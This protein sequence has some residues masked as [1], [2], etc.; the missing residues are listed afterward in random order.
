M[1]L[2]PSKI[3]TSRYFY[4]YAVESEHKEKIS[5]RGHRVTVWMSQRK[6]ADV[7]ALSTTRV[8]YQ[9]DPYL[10]H[11]RYHVLASAS[12]FLT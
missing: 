7:R 10:T 3:S 6:M 11:L 2:V 5:I 12:C 9:R 4:N 8:Q 1:D